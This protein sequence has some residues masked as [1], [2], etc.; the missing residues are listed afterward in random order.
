MRG[1]WILLGLG[2][3]AAQEVAVDT[4]SSEPS[5]EATPLFR[6][7]AGGGAVYIAPQ[8]APIEEQ[9]DVARRSVVPSQP[10]E[11][12]THAQASPY[13]RVGSPS[14]KSPISRKPSP[15]K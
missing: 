14:R 2:F 15:E 10:M 12:D 4:F 11:R 13:M 6:R 1:V 7:R 8:A 5:E 3:L 9:S